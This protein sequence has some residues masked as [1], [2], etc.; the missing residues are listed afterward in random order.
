MTGD[1]IDALARRREPLPNRAGLAA[2]KLYHALTLLYREYRAGVTDA[3]TA[4]VE[5]R[6]LLQEYEIEALWER[7]YEDAARRRRALGRLLIS[8]NKE[9]CPIC[10]K[11]A[12][13][14]DGRAAVFDEEGDV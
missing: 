10:Q 5:K 4:K 12:K 1:Q 3:R 2:R 8:A 6:K 7:I 14:I 11:M 9:G 13:V